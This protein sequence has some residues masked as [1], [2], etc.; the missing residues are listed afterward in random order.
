MLRL[1]VVIGGWPTI[2][3]EVSPE[4]VSSGVLLDEDEFQVK[5]V[6]VDH[7][8]PCLA[9]AFEGKGYA[10]TCGAKGSACSGLA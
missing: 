7:G 2:R 5:G 9:F 4:Q 8:I 10:L 1:I 6:V 3:S